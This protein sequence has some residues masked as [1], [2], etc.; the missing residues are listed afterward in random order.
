M[1]R[2]ARRPRHGAAVVFVFATY[3]AALAVSA[4]LAPRARGQ[5]SPP[6]ATDRDC[7]NGYLSTLADTVRAVR[8]TVPVAVDGVLDEAVWQRP[9]AAPLVQNDPD[10]GCP[11]RQ[12]TDWWVAYDD[13][14]LYVAARMY[15]SAPDSHRARLGAA[16]HLA[17]VATGSS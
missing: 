15:D 12:L 2:L 1:I 9:S 7:H 6:P 5:D 16:R 11:P 10:N 8:T 4:G 3:A 17:R 14:A 13:E